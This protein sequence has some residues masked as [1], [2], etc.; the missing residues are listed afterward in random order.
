MGG[1]GEVWSKIKEAILSMQENREVLPTTHSSYPTITESVST[2][3][4]VEISVAATFATHFALAYNFTIT[5]KHKRFTVETSFN[6]H[7]EEGGGGGSILNELMRYL[8]I[9]FSSHSSSLMTAQ[10]V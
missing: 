4:D 5:L 1:G 6:F 3:Q 8:P 10:D 9:M 7:R 2:A